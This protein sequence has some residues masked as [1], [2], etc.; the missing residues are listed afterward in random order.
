MARSVSVSVVHFQAVPSSL[1]L[2]TRSSVIPARARSRVHE[3]HA[4]TYSLH[5]STLLATTTTCT[6][7]EC[8]AVTSKWPGRRLGQGRVCSLLAQAQLA[9]RTRK[10]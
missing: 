1:P 6:R 8:A 5:S 10:D 4:S 9:V 7:T 3:E 2:R